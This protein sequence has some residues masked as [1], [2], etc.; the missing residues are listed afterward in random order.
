[1][2]ECYLTPN[3]RKKLISRVLS[4]I[5]EDEDYFLIVPLRQSAPVKAIGM[6][7]PPIDAGFL[8]IG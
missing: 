4:V 1:M 2:F 7:T 6:A 5:C 8:Y 3:E